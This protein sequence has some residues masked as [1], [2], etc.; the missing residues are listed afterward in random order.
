MLSQTNIDLESLL[1]TLGTNIPKAQNISAY[2][3]LIIWADKQ[4]EKCPKT[5]SKVLEYER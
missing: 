4:P 3:I 1:Q 2:S 5:H